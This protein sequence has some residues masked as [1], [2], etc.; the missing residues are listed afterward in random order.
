MPPT[1]SVT[2]RPAFEYVV[3]AARRKE[4]MTRPAGSSTTDRR[5]KVGFWGLM[6]PRPI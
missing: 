2:E 3:M 4:R 1:S 6:S 5:R